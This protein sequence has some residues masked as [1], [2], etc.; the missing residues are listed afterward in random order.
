MKFIGVRKMRDIIMENDKKINI[1]IVDDCKDFCNILND[2]LSNQRD[3]V[4]IGIANDGLELLKLIKIK[5]PDLIILDII[6]P[7]LDGL[8]V[9]ERLNKMN[10]DPMPLIIISSAI[11]DDTIIQRALTLGADRYI[12]KPFDLDEFIKMVRE[13]FDNVLHI[14]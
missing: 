7:H 8:G 3:I 4:V 9:L 10:I 12:I 2:Y 1:V 13:L 14:Y 11:S 6:M 5:R